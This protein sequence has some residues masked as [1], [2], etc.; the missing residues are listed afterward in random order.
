MVAMWS[1]VVLV[2]TILVICSG[3]VLVVTENAVKQ[4]ELHVLRTWENCLKGQHLFD[5]VSL[6]GMIVYLTFR[7]ILVHL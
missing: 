7:V 2:V 4:T 5:S 6:G 3:I 1:C